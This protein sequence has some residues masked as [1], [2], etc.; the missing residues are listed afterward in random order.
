MR[1]ELCRKGLFC[2]Q[3]GAQTLRHTEQYV[4]YCSRVLATDEASGHF[5]RAGGF[6]E[7]WRCEQKSEWMTAPHPHS[8]R[9]TAT[10]P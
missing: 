10:D 2:V 3:T 5:G 6:A 9:K 8:A 7:E 4:E 1:G